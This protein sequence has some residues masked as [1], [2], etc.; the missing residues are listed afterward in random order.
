MI[1][2]RYIF[3]LHLSMQKSRKTPSKKRKP[4]RTTSVQVRLTEGEKELLREAAELE[5]LA[6]ST[7]LRSKVIGAARQALRA[8]EAARARSPRSKL[9][10]GNK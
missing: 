5:A 8:D 4:R 7:W 1:D 10:R 2:K 9:E 3:V 6:L